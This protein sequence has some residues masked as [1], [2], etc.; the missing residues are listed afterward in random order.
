M[1]QIP[2]ETEFEK[3]PAKT[4]LK[5]KKLDF[6][7]DDSGIVIKTEKGLVIISGCAHAG[8]CN[9]IEYAKKITKE[10]NVYA[11]MGGFHLRI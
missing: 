3:I 7:D 9:T 10:N 4:V 1:G 5:D 11:V 2:R 8:I 6:V